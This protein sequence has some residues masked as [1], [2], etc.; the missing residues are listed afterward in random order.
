MALGVVEGIWSGGEL[1]ALCATEDLFGRF[2]RLASLP[3]LHDEGISRFGH[4]AGAPIA[5][6]ED[7]V[8][9]Y[10]GHPLLGLGKDETA[11]NELAGLQIEL[12]QR[13]SIF[14]ARRERDQA[15]PVA[16]I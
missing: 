12:A 3:E 11:V 15:Q 9:V 13:S 2:Q 16:G 4:G 5:R 14:T 7:G 8:F 1:I 6:H 10:P